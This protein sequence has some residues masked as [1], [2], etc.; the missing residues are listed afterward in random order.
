MNKKA[1]NATIFGIAAGIL[2]VPI[3]RAVIRK[4]RKPA[5]GK[6]LEGAPP[7]NLFSAYRGK[8]KPHHRKAKDRRAH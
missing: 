1:R 4:Y 5:A 8:F 3:I 7:N 6:T 2:M